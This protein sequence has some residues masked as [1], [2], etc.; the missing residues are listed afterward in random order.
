VLSIEAI[1]TLEHSKEYENIISITQYSKFYLLFSFEK[2]DEWIP[3]SQIYY[4]N[5]RKEIGQNEKL[6]MHKV[7]GILLSVVSVN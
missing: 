2:V 1:A 6:Q 4:F 5:V 3:I 7:L